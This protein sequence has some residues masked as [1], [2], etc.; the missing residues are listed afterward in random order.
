[1]KPGDWRCGDCTFVNFARRDYCK[2]C[3][4]PRPAR[5]AGAGASF[6]QGRPG[7][8]NCGGCNYLNFAY[9]EVCGQCGDAKG[10]G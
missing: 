9:R 1:M 5:E 10:E 2:D 4:A 3:G 8:W 6:S 7:D